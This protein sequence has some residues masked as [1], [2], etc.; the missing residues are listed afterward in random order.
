MSTKTFISLILLISL[1]GCGRQNDAEKT[2]GNTLGTTV[3]EAEQTIDSNIKSI[4]QNYRQQA[5]DEFPQTQENV[6]NRDR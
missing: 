3:K 4:E 5:Y 2:T 1:T 6:D